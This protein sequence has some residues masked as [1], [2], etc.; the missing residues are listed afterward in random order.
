MQVLVP[1]VYRMLTKMVCSELEKV[2]VYQTVL[3][4]PLIPNTT[5]LQNAVGDYRLE[6]VTGLSL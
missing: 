3:W 1:V 4:A 5:L 2:E 6:G